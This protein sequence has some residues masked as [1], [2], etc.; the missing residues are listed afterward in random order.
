MA[1]FGICTPGPGVDISLDYDDLTLLVGAVNYQN[2]SD[3]QA[4]VTLTIGG[5]AH[6]VA[7]AP[8]TPRTTKDVSGLGIHMVVTLPPKGLPSVG[9]PSTISVHCAWPA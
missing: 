2:L 9:L 1:N 7:L 6:P 5:T 4:V 8:N 3:Q